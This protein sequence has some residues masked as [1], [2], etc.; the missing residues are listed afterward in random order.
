MV[1]LQSPQAQLGVLFAY[2][3]VLIA[4]PSLLTPSALAAARPGRARV[5]EDTWREQVVLAGSGLA[6]IL[7]TNLLGAQALVVAGSLTGAVFSAAIVAGVHGARG[8]YPFFVAAKV[9]DDCVRTMTRVCLVTMTMTYPREQRK[10]RV[11]AMFQ[12][13]LDV[14]LTMGQGLRRHRVSAVAAAW[15]RLAFVCASAAC[16]AWVVPTDAVVRDSGVFVLAR[17]T[18]SLRTELRRTARIFG[19]RYMLL[20]VP[21][22][23][24]YPFALGV[25]GVEL[26]DRQ[27]V[28][29]YNIGSLSALALA[30]VLDA[31]S[32]HR[33]RRA[34]LGFAATSVVTLAAVSS[35]AVLTTLP[36]DMAQL[37]ALV[38]LPG[39]PANAFRLLH[40]RALF[41]ATVFLNGMSISCV[42]L[43]SAWIIGSLTND[44]EYTARFSGTLL[45]VPALGTMVALLCIGPEDTHVGVPPNAPLY[46]GIALLAASSCAMYCV[47]RRITDTNDW[48]LMYIR[49]APRPAAPLAA[50]LV[51]SCM[52]AARGGSSGTVASTDHG[53]IIKRPL[54]P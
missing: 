53:S 18:R 15:A 29:L 21:Y 37:P 5:Y 54:T 39:S 47:V 28:L 23:F 52:V 19:N 14:F 6:G 7:A 38:S 27:S 12:L 50:P 9:V 8:W 41:Y 4:V 24:S 25:L 17:P 51:E 40:H 3:V 16:V 10:A 43:F 11:M 45:S 13:M 46:V 30:A 34:Q 26:P 2:S 44:V 48:S 35:M 31:G 42:F 49:S 22:M 33:R 36:V 32:R 20:L 1:R